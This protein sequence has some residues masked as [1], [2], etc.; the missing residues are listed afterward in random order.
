MVRAANTG[1]SAVIDL[2]GTVRTQT[3]LYETTFLVEELAWPRV[4][5]FYAAYGDVFARLCALAT[6]GMLGYA[7]Y[8]KR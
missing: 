4:T 3:A 8:K 6:V 2:D 5:S 1:F 7:H